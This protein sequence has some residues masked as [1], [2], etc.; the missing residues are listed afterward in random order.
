MLYANFRNGLWKERDAIEK[1]D[2]ARFQIMADFETVVDSV[3][4][5]GCS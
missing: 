1:R 4:G 3:M 5:L 2:F